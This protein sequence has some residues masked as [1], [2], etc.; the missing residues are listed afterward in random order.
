ML[1]LKSTAWEGRRTEQY[2]DHGTWG[3]QYYLT[4]SHDAVTL[5]EIMPW[6]LHWCHTGHFLSGARSS[7]RDIICFLSSK[8]GKVAGKLKYLHSACCVPRPDYLHPLVATMY[9]RQ[10]LQI[11]RTNNTFK[12][13]GGFSPQSGCVIYTVHFWRQRAKRH[14]P[15]GLPQTGLPSILPAFT[16]IDILLPPP[17]SKMAFDG[18]DSKMGC[19]YLGENLIP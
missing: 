8:D 1:Q 14:M 6:S 9:P 3:R 19:L 17:N 16:G 2:G 15:G 7:L 4:L 18:K 5:T 12:T 10:Q 13:V 11:H